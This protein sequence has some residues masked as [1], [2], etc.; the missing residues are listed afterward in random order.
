[1]QM[2]I[3]A[4]LA[5]Y[6]QQHGEELR[7]IPLRRRPISRQS[8]GY[9]SLQIFLSFFS[10]TLH[11]FL[12]ACVAAVDRPPPSALPF[13][14]VTMSVMTSTVYSA[15]GDKV[16]AWDSAAKRSDSIDFVK[17]AF[18]AFDVDKSGYIRTLLSGLNV[19]RYYRARR[20]ASPHAHAGWQDAELRRIFYDVTQTL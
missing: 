3:S 13:L 6:F 11:F 14:T 5:P 17:K 15:F 4:F 12:A 1:M 16:G 20:H 10:W 8:D 18:E 2:W 19:W 7:T 9:I